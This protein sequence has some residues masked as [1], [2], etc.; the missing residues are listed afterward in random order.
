MVRS[1]ATT[2]LAQAA[3]VVPIN[4]GEWFTEEVIADGDVITVIVQGVE[5]REA[6]FPIAN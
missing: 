6:R 3:P 5:V 2:K 4:P 1:L